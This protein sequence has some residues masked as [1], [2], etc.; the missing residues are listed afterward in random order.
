M[1][2]KQS[3]IHKAARLLRGARAAVAFTGAGISVPSGIPDF[4]SPGGLWSKYD[5]MKVASLQALRTDPE[6]VWRFLYEANDMFRAAE[7]NPAHIALADMEAAGLLVGVIT[8][9]IDGLHQRAGSRDVVEFHGSADRY[10]CMRCGIDYAEVNVRQHAAG[11][12][13]PTCPDCGGVIRPEVVFFGEGIPQDAKKWADELIRQA[14]CILVVGTSG[15]VMP[16]SA[17]PYRVKNAGGSMIEVNLGR[18][19]YGDLADVRLDARA[20]E[21]LPQLYECVIS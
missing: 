13:P 7:P 19:A 16:A 14:D 18:T 11:G 20:E 4:R 15:E 5:P 1:K 10:S 6:S 3:L 9:N 21:V 8:Q 2:D 12:K 17:F